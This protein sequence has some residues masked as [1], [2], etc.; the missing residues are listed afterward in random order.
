MKKR[1]TTTV[2]IEMS[3]SKQQRRRSEKN[4]MRDVKIINFY[5]FVEQFSGRRKAFP[6]SNW[7]K[8]RLLKVK[9]QK[10]TSS[11]IILSSSERGIFS[12]QTGIA[13]VSKGLSG[14]WYSR[15]S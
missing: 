9:F 4:N 6:A 2:Q 7:S 14:Y 3:V 10:L 15:S 8:S 5:V 13:T 11:M 12:F 1:Q